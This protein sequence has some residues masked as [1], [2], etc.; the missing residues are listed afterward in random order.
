M[1]L[2]LVDNRYSILRELGGGGMTKVY[3][4]HDETLDRDLALKV[5]REQFAEDAEF[6]ERFK[7]EAQSAAALS[8]TSIVQVYD[9][10]EGDDSAP[11]IAMEYVAGGTL[12]GLILGR[13]PLETAVAVSIA[14]H[15]TEA[16][17]A[18][19]EKGIV[20]RD[21][22]PQNILLTTT[23]DAKVADFGIARAASAAT[24]S[25]TG[26]IL[27]TAS[28]MSPEQALGKP[29]TPESDLYS[30]GVVLYEM[31][32]GQLPYTAES[33]V[34]VSMKHLNE[35]LRS[36]KEVNPRIPENMNL[37]VVKLLAK[38]PQDRYE[39]AAELAEDL[40]RVRDGLPPI[41]AGFAANETETTRVDAPATV[42]VVSVAARKGRWGRMLW[43]LAATLTLVVL[44]GGLAWA[45]WQGFWQQ[46]SALGEASRP[47]GVEVPSVEGQTEEQ[48][49]EKLTDS[50]FAVDIRRRESSTA[51]SEKVLEQSPAAGERAKK[52]SR[53]LIEVGDGLLGVEV[54]DV[55]GL[56][57][58]EAKA[59]L[60]NG[61]LTVGLQREIPSNTAPEDVV[62][63]QGHLAGEKVE[64]GT[65]VNLGVSSGPQQV[66]AP[67]AVPVSA[68]ASAPTVAPPA[69]SALGE[70]A[71]GGK[72]IGD[73]NSGPGSSG[74]G[75]SGPGGGG[76][77]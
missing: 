56:G 9:R 74:S 6:A 37:V 2:T 76:G 67:A 1:E 44:L 70:G 23:G 51:N 4:A 5:P 55:V 40:R 22:K 45:L 14:L 41:A 52:G 64:P 71:A 12:K 63:E 29:A 32:T 20:H 36:P 53:V 50:G 7:R 58:S 31:L 25:Q 68:S 21:I 39:D 34:A 75:N 24:I 72:G 16:L 15:V 28:Y 18:A 10:G 66:V 69:V 35:P 3:L 26:L 59:A 49:Q 17:G 73:D 62:V 30:L 13:G 47:T 19:H 43:V 48:A 33:P 42:R 60:D 11:Y 27:G 57:L 77:D 61:G 54:P 46:D 38:D 65:A 8:H